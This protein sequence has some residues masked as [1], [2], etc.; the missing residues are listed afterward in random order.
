MQ[1]IKFKHDKKACALYIKVGR[2]R[3]AKT[4][5]SSPGFIVDYDKNGGII[6]VEMLNVSPTS[7]SKKFTINLEKL[8]R[9]SK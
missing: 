9:I 8:Q 2:G 7:N 1:K 4:L 3:V 6:G 5:E